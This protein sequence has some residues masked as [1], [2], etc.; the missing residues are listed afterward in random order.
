MN[1]AKQLKGFY[2]TKHSSETL[3]KA[4]R[5]TFACQKQKSRKLEMLVP[6]QLL[7][8]I[9]DLSFVDIGYLIAHAHFHFFYI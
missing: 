2:K 3:T 6:Y 7:A 5:C 4:W 1:S 8:N 9:I